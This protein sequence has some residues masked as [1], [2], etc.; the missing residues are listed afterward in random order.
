MEP[1][2]FQKS[3]PSQAS[4]T[5]FFLLSL[6]FLLALEIRLE[7]LY[8]SAQCYGRIALFGGVNTLKRLFF[9]PFGSLFPAA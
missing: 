7:L 8:F 5:L 4:Q 3:I 1:F 2:L 6:F 9:T